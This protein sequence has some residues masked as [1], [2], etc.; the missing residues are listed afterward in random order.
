MAGFHGGG[1]EVDEDGAVLA[2][3]SDGSDAARHGAELVAHPD[4]AD[5]LDVCLVQAGIG[6]GEDAKGHGGGGI[7]GQHH[8]RQ[9]VGRHGRQRAQ[10]QLAGHGQGAV[11]VNVVAEVDADDADAGHRLGH[12]LAGA[13]RLIAP[14]FDAVGDGLFDG[15]GRHALIV[16][17]DLHRRR[18]EDRQNVHRDAATAR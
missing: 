11:G 7:E 16:G 13:G 5:I 2:A 3:D 17:D 9:R 8:R 18:L 4:A 14:A 6:D 15:G 12:D 10:S 1:L